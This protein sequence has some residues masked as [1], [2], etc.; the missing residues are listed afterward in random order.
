MASRGLKTDA[1][2]KSETWLS[3]PAYLLHPEQDWP[4]SPGCLAELMSNDPQVKVRVAVNVVQTSEDVDAT[5][6]LIHHSSS[7]TRLRRAVVWVIRLKNLLWC[8]SQEEMTRHSL[9]P[10]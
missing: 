8:L 1:F 7:W 3:G 4:V 10:V 5:T 9:Q 2:L 6:Q